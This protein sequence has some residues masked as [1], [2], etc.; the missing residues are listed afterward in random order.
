[1]D[2]KEAKEKTIQKWKRISLNFPT[3]MTYEELY[4]ETNKNCGFC[5]W[6][7]ES[8]TRFCHAD[9][10]AVNLCTGI[11][12]II[13]DL[14]VYEDD[15]MTVFISRLIDLLIKGLEEIEV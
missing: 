4:A 3:E 9:C 14:V 12:S 11:R 15:N 5:K 7:H 2:L 8:G 13:S 10:P 1:M 6:K